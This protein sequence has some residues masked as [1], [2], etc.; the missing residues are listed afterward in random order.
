M[1][2]VDEHHSRGIEIVFTGLRPGEKLYEELLIGE[3]DQPTRHP[4]IMT[5]NEDSLTWDELSDYIGQFE[6]A[7]DVND[8]EKSRQ[9]LVE[10]VKDFNP[11]CD[12]ADLVE[13]KKQASNG[14]ARDNV[15]PYPG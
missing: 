7:I 5:A 3:N 4:L 10:S 8:V 2:I 15:I 6:A 1:D 11:Q 9:L 14:P 12:V 13:E